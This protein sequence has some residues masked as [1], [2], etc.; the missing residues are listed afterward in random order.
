VNWDSRSGRTLERVLIG[1]ASL[2]IAVG[3]IAL[4]S[5]YF[6]ANDQAGVNGRSGGPGQAFADQGDAHLPVDSLRPS[7]N[8]DP[9]T[10]GGHVVEH[11]SRDGQVLN[12]YQVLTALAVGDVVIL[13]G[14]R[15][16]P[17]ALRAAAAA[18]AGPFTPLLAA[19]GGAVVLARRPGLNGLI[20]LAWTRMLRVGSVDPALRRFATYWLGKGAAGR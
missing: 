19:D 3:A 2:V 15:R 5:G 13:Y 9:P 14:G 8:S 12:D 16:P 17:P 7:Y 6:A 18:V 20:G 11:V 10:S 1:V 4:L